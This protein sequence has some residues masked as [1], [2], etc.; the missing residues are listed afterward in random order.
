MAREIFLSYENDEES[1]RIADDIRTALSSIDGFEITSIY[2]L[3][4]RARISNYLKRLSKGEYIILIVGESFLKSKERLE[5]IS[6]ILQDDDFEERCFPVL[7]PSANIQ[8]L[9]GQINYIQYWNELLSSHSRELTKLAQEEPTLIVEQAKDFR[10]LTISLFALDTF[11]SK[12]ADMKVWMSEDLIESKYQTLVNAVTNHNP[13]GIEHVLFLASDP[14]G[15][16][17]LR[18]GVEYR[19]L[20]QLFAQKRA[21]R[22]LE[23]E[24]SPAATYEDLENSI[25]KYSPRIVHFSGHG[26]LTGELC[27]RDDDGEIYAVTPEE[28][29][30]LF[31]KVSHIVELVFL[32]VCFSEEQANS[33]SRH[34]SKVIGMKKLIDDDVAR[35]FAMSFYTA[36]L[37]GLQTEDAF[38]KSLKIIGE[39][40]FSD[41]AEPLIL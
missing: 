22:N 15:T 13:N 34:I 32:N 17:Y 12:V 31:S 26:A 8:M 40:E 1:K 37:S 21:Y 2:D 33:I 20:K 9:I 35:E 39:L 4:Y 7:L 19:D 16:E 5:E 25:L 24:I 3:G 29:G 41:G 36:I 10:K 11:M 38:N 18:H 27:L 6:R 14:I 28:L 23:I 30:E